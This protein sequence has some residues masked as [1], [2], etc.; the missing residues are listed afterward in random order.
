MK[1]KGKRKENL[2]KEDVDKR[3]LEKLEITKVDFRKR[4]QFSTIMGAGNVFK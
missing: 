2:M 3:G 1:E 4:I